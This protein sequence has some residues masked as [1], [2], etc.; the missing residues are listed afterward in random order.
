M[1]A[2]KSTWAMLLLILIA[3]GCAE[4]VAVDAEPR[5]SQ[6]K[7]KFGLS[8]AK[9]EAVVVSNSSSKNSLSVSF[10][11]PDHFA[12]LQVAVSDITNNKEFADVPWESIEEQLLP[13]VGAKNAKLA[14]VER[15]WILVDRENLSPIPGA[16]GGSP[17][18]MVLEYQQAFDADDLAIAIKTKRIE[19]EDQQSDKARGSKAAS[20][21]SA[22]RLDEKRIAIGNVGLT[23][24]LLE[25]GGSETGLGQMFGQLEI[26]SEINGLVS[27]QPIRSFLQGIFDMASSFSPALKKLAS[28]PDLT[29][30]I[31]LAFSVDNEKMLV[32]NIVMEDEQMTKDLTR[33]LNE[34]LVNGGAAGS[35]GMPSFASMGGGKAPMTMSPVEST[36][37]MEEVGK[38]IR[39]NQLLSVSS[40]ENTVSIT[41]NRPEKIKQ[42]VAAV[43]N[44]GQKQML[45]AERKRRLEKIGSA[46]K[47]YENAHGCLPSSEVIVDDPDGLPNQFSWRVAIL[48]EL[49]EQ[50]IYDQ[51]DFSKPW[52]GPE[53][54]KAAEQIPEVFKNVMEELGN[55]TRLHIPGGKSGLYRIDRV[56]PKL[57]DISDK[58][59]WTAIVISGGSKSAE[60]WTRPSVLSVDSAEEDSFGE[61]GENGV[62]VINAAFKSRIAKRNNGA[63]TAMLTTDGEEKLNRKDFLS[64]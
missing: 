63:V 32:A 42:L 53:N 3:V 64:N 56:R 62:F 50:D 43:V 4:P 15:L 44:D 24:K 59:I 45:V 31:D 47:A 5:T 7:A 13:W 27:I 38:D 48:P 46:L 26:E 34:Q 51:F 52:D 35:G 28:L 19:L 8:D 14:V 2:W 12:C 30:Q 11:H 20:Q 41:L 25:G 10:L 22:M 33:L 57:S 23:T 58:S 37:I 1:K 61:D 6:F 55:R 17:V 16:G 21:F 29:Q 49:G 60:V 54:L 18:V 9:S 39:D 40:I 36:P